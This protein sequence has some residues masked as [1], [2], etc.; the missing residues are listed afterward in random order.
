MN[1][2]SLKIS[3]QTICMA[4]FLL[5]FSIAVVIVLTPLYSLAIDWFSIEE[6]TGFSKEILTKNYQVLI[7]YL[8]NPF[9][10]HLQMPD[11]SSSTN[12][13]QHFRDVKQLFL[14]DLACVPL[15]GG[16]TYW[17]LQQMKQQKTYWYYIKPFWWMIVTPLSLAI[18]GSVTFR[19][20]FLL[21]HKLMFRNTTWLFDPKYDPI[22]LA[23]PEQYFMM[24]FVLILGLFT[25]L[26]ISLEL[27]VRRKA[28][29]NR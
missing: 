10:S 26:A 1:H 19:D 22:I 8:I 9:D 12:G 3:L 4:L 16:V 13:L 6:Q 20:A 18:V 27:M 14:L 24:C 17:L 21:F 5:S 11:F 15:L 28:K 7:Q 29:I 25:V 23:L 2:Q